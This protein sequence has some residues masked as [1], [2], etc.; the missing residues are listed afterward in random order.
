MSYMYA[1]GRFGDRWVKTSKLLK[2]LSATLGE[3]SKALRGSSCEQ[4]SLSGKQRST[5][6]NK[7]IMNKQGVVTSEK[8]IP[9]SER[10]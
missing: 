5:C 1:I 9:S 3:K 6:S 8:E 4:L 10:V 2:I 7:E